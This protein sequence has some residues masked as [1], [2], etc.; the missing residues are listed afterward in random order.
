MATPP[1]KT[2]SS[3]PGGS[4]EKAQGGGGRM[5]N[6]RPVWIGMAVSVMILALLGWIAAGRRQP[7]VVPQHVGIE[8]GHA[9]VGDGFGQQGRRRE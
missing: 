5:L 2:V 3:V 1:V 4:S 9:G 8:Y 7:A 6:R